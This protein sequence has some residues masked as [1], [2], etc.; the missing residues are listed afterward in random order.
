MRQAPPTT[1]HIH[2]KKAALIQEAAFS[3][4]RKHPFMKGGADIEYRAA[5]KFALHRKSVKLPAQ[6]S[7]V[8]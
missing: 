2:K 6:K 7:S 4:G 5:A 1:K 8:S 3:L